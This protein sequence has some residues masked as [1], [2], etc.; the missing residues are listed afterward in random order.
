MSLSVCVCV[1][2]LR[3]H[4]PRRPQRRLFMP[5]VPLEMVQAMGQLDKAYV[6][7]ECDERKG[8]VP[9]EG[10]GGGSRGGT[11]LPLRS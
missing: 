9:F 1:W 4:K 3:L 2:R 6:D 5:H 11:G 7:A 8:R 10:G